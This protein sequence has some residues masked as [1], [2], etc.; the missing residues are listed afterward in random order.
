MFFK[1]LDFQHNPLQTIKKQQFYLQYI[2]S[3]SNQLTWMNVT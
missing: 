1:S 2:S 3:E